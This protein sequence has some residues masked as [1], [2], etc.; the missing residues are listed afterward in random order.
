MKFRF[1]KRKKETSNGGIKEIIAKLSRGLMLP[2]AM[3]PIA[4][5]FLGVGAAIVNNVSQD[6]FLYILG[7]VLN[8]AGNVVFSALPV[9]FA[10]AIAITFTGDAGVAGLSAFVG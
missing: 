6:N 3:L 5:I 2:I 9:L 1:F 8:G 10:V 7:S 4:G